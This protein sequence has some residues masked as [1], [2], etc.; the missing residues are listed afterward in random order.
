MLDD[1]TSG[2]FLEAFIVSASDDQQ[3]EF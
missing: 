1:F 2:T 3:Q